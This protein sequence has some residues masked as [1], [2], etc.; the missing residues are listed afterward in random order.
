MIVEFIISYHAIIIWYWR[1]LS[2]RAALL[3]GQIHCTLSMRESLMICD[4]LINGWTTSNTYCGVEISA[5]QYTTVCS[6]TAIL[7][8]DTA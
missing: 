5:E 7:F 4:N 8:T 1:L 2:Y 6:Y 3:V